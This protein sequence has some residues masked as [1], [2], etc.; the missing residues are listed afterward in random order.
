MIFW[1]IKHMGIEVLRLARPRASP[2]PV[3]GGGVVLKESQSDNL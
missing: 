1:A 2:N 3:V